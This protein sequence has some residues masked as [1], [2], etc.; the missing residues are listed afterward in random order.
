[1]LKAIQI[2]FLTMLVLAA[3]VRGQSQRD[4][5]RGREGSQTQSQSKEAQQQRADDQRGTDQ[6]PLSVKVMPTSESEEK[7]ARDTKDREEKMEL[8]RNLVQFNGDMAYYTKVLAWVAGLQ[9]FAL[10]VQAIVFAFTLGAT[11]K[12]ADAAR[13]ALIATARPKIIVRR[14]EAHFPLPPRRSVSAQFRITNVG[15]NGAIL[16][17]RNAILVA[18]IQQGGQPFPEYPIGSA[19]KDGHRLESGDFVADPDTFF[20]SASIDPSE[21]EIRSGTSMLFLVGYVKYRDEA[22]VVREMGFGRKFDPKTNRFHP[23]KDPEVEYGD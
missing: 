21:E 15:G 5:K 8:D 12:A 7:T 1:M 17:E 14:V 22:G 9:L 4:P 2:A 3:D 10:I 13:G 18:S 19:T 6:M 16:V 11:R 23:L 20:A